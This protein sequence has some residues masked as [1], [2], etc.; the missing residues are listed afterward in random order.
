M[1]DG[2][3]LSNILVLRLF[4]KYRKVNRELAFGGVDIF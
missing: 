4:F 1:R 2:Y 3:F